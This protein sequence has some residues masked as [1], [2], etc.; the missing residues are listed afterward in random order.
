MTIAKLLNQNFFRVPKL[1]LTALGC[2]DTNARHLNNK[3]LSHELKILNYDGLWEKK[4]TPDENQR[5]DWRK[6]IH[7]YQLVNIGW[8]ADIN[9]FNSM[10]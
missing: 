1:P 5:F 9:L 7:G 4:K 3:L 6:S 8:L 2:Y 10:I